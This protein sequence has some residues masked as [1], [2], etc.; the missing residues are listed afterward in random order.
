MG[1][2]LIN[3]KE[4]TELNSLKN[5][6]YEQGMDQFLGYSMMPTDGLM[7][8]KDGA[9]S[10]S[11]HYQGPDVD[12]S[13]DQ[14]LDTL[15]AQLVNLLRH[16]GNGWML[17][18]NVTRSFSKSYSKPSNFPDRVSALIEEERRAQYQS[19]GAHFDTTNY[20]TITHISPDVMEKADKKHKGVLDFTPEAK[21]N[22]TSFDS[23]ERDF[24]NDLEKFE[25][26]L[27]SYIQ[28]TRLKGEA[29]LTFLN[30]C[31]SGRRQVVAVPNFPMEMDSYLS[32]ELIGGLKP[33][34][35][36]KYVR[37]LSLSE[38][39]QSSYPTFFDFMNKLPLEYRWSMRYITLSRSDAENYLK[40]YRKMWRKKAMGLLGMIRSGSGNSQAIQYDRD[41]LEMVEAIDDGIQA[42]NSDL[43]RYGFL[44]NTLVLMDE[45]L[46]ILEEKVKFV[47]GEL[48][49]RGFFVIDET[50]NNL[51]AYFG[52]IPSHGYYNVRR[53][54]L[55]SILVSHAAPLSSVWQG[56][57]YCPCDFYK[58]DPAPPLFYSATS[59]GTPFRFNLHVKDVGHTLIIGPTGAG[60]STLLGL[61][62]A[63]HR[64]YINSHIFVFD[65]DYS[66]RAIIKALGGDY[67]DIEKEDSISFAPLSG[68]D[69]PEEFDWACDY[70]ENMLIL[71]GLKVDSFIK[72]EIRHALKM[73][74]HTP[75]EYWS[76]DH[77][78]TFIQHKEVRMALSPYV[79][80]ALLKRLLGGTSD[81]IETG[82]VMGLELGWLSKA[83]PAT[84]GP[85]LDYLFNMLGR[86]FKAGYPTLLILEE[87]WLFLQHSSFRKKIED[88]L[89]TL[90]KMNVAVIINSQSCSDV[91]E[92]PIGTI[93]TDSCATK[94]FLPNDKINDQSRPSYYYFGLNER[95]VDIIQHAVS[96]KHYYVTS[97]VGKRLI[98]LGLGQVALAFM[99]NSAE[100]AKKLCK[101]IDSGRPHWIYEWLLYKSDNQKDPERASLLKEWAEHALKT[102]NR[103][104]EARWEGE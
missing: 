63:Q 39:P 22:E 50:L 10:A 13:T 5:S 41:A 12:S 99:G 77:L 31:I 18:F 91:S 15:S 66:N 95:Q 57:E 21:A 68:I 96:K 94:V 71:Q 48:E 54:L 82:S 32:K 35:G 17:E 53:P 59:G 24:E 44:S 88:W 43:I 47:I 101:L 38:F 70:I 45:D 65:K 33:K 26:I 81:T 85:L 3:K 42:N 30:L 56:Q 9:L 83:S 7:M 49:Q 76:L 61:I 84:S 27:S 72:Q 79:D 93:I 103:A 87:A 104:V 102:E 6:R 62:I 19:E 14:E 11:Y 100:E 2:L 29:L 80:S 97:P 40:K 4:N 78:S 37:T 67:Y 16:F 74:L 90:R 73:L 86:T 60:K 36:G 51:E 64:K 23:I 28:V 58:P 89:R 69:R 8:M 25:N 20:L 46:S 34:V 75:K 55:D 1:L 92:S 98:D 52:S